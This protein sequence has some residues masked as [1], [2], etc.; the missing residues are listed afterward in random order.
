MSKDQPT[1]E[2]KKFLKDFIKAKENNVIL[3]K[4]SNLYDKAIKVL[5]K[6]P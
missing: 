1:S 3:V 5:K 2:I 4:L 6:L